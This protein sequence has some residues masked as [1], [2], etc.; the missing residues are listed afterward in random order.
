MVDAVVLTLLLA[1]STLA[2]FLGSLLGLG[3]GILLIPLLLTIVPGM[4]IHH[5]IGTS[6]VAVVATSSAAG[7]VYAQEG[8]SNLRLGML[9]EVGTTLGA[10]TGAFVAILLSPVLLEVLF[11][12][13]AF[14][15]AF[16]MASAK[17][18]HGLD[19]PAPEEPPSRNPLERI[20]LAGDFI[21]P[22]SG[23]HYYYRPKRKTLGMVV[24]YFAG[25]LSGLL[26]IGGGPIKVPA[27]NFVMKVPMRVSVAT[28][29][30]MIG[31]TAAASAFIYY[32]G[33]FVIPPVAG[34]AIVGVFF[35][36]ILGLRVGKKVAGLTL[37]RAF[38]SVL[39]ALGAVMLLRALGYAGGVP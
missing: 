8:V 24:G 1:G 22:K 14:Y 31:V 26:G 37:K 39:I 17:H 38:S 19:H 10:L 2:G 35:G 21:D 6:L 32:H 25:I 16:Y 9:L 4:E 7:S 15:A 20:D 30:F 36:S 12:L 5:A 11:A 34:I 28:S 33:G 13:G 29:N 23:L 18:T 27:M 3:G